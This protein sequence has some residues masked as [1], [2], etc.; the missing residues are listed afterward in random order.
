MK[1]Y[2]M[3]NKTEAGPQKRGRRRHPSPRYAIA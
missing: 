3:E 1:R 2:K